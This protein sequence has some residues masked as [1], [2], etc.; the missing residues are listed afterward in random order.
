MPLVNG[1]NNSPSK[2]GRS[3][4]SPSYA[5]LNL[6]QSSLRSGIGLRMGDALEEEDEE[7]EEME[8]QRIADDMEVED[9]PP[10]ESVEQ[11][12]VI[13]DFG[14]EDMEM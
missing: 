6:P 1:Y 12:E 5:S 2:H 3:L 14:A 10:A 9:S 11:D 13:E 7:E 8:R 4:L